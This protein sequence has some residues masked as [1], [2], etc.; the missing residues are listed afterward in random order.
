MR[1]TY[2]VEITINKP[3]D[4]VIRIMFDYHQMRFYGVPI[5]DHHVHLEG[6]PPLEGAVT[7]LYYKHQDETVKMVEVILNNNLPT[8]I[9][10]QYT[11]GTVKN[12]CKD[13]F[14][15]TNGSTIWKMD[16]LFVFPENKPIN[17]EEFKKKTL[18][19]MNAFKDYIELI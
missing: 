3:I 17:K 8:S 13:F 5:L 7:E 18:N 4:D 1:I 9:T 10:R 16:V 19:Q 12:E 15:E 11:L 2:E 14:T 6:K